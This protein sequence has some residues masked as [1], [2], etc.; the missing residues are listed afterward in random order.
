M[1]KPV[2]TIQYSIV[3]PVYNTTQ[4]LHELQQRIEQVFT[5]HIRQPY[6]IVLVDDASPNPETWPIV[7]NLVQQHSNISAIRLT[8]NFGQHAAI[9]CGLAHAKG[10]HIL[11]MDDDLQ[12]APEDILILIGQQE[13]DVVIGQLLLKKHSWA[14]NLF[15]RMKAWFDRAL[16]GKPRDLRVSTFCLI[17][18][19]TVEQ[20][21]TMAHIPYPLLSSLIFYVTKD[22]VGVPVSHSLRREGKSGY[23]LTTLIRLFSRLLVNN[24]KLIFQFVIWCGA[25]L[26]TL[27]LVMLIGLLLWQLIWQGVPGWLFF[28]STILLS[29]GFLLLALGFLGVSF[30]HIAAVAEQKKPYLIRQKI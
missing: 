6:E 25:L 19:S 20:M 15:S 28:G 12:H 8:R 4:V 27:N 29:N 5:T 13:H 24:S 16:S 9:L 18:R 7:E 23:S 17:R 21:L 10:A 30:S 3:I 1:M 22:V 11:T 14:R 2:A 26:F